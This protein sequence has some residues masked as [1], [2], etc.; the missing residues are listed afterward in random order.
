MSAVPPPCATWPTNSQAPGRARAPAPS[1]PRLL[2]LH[3]HT[4]TFPLSQVDNI[5]WGEGE[6]AVIAKL[7]SG[8]YRVCVVV[9]LGSG[10]SFKPKKPCH[11]FPESGPLRCARGLE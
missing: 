9:G 10:S 5:M 11:P 6:R 2:N 1:L 8:D 4:L 7:A 3:S